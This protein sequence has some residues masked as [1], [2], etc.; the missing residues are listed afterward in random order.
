MAITLNYPV[1]NFDFGSANIFLGTSMRLFTTVTTTMSIP[2]WESLPK[3]FY[4]DNGWLPFRCTELLL[5]K[6]VG[7]IVRLISFVIWKY[8]QFSFVYQFVTATAIK[9]PEQQQQLLML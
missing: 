7:I 5:P 6:E 4:F 8:K 2:S 9:Q 1:Q 3:C